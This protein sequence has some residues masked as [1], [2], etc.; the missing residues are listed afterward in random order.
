MVKLGPYIIDLP[1]CR[2]HVLGIVQALSSL[3]SGRVSCP[4]GFMVWVS[5]CSCCLVLLPS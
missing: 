1:V 3:G 4:H 5:L 2:G